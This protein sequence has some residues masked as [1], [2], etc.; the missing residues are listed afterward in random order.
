MEETFLVLGTLLKKL[1]VFGGGVGGCIFW[2]FHMKG[3]IS[4][5][6]LGGYLFFIIINSSTLF[7]LFMRRIHEEEREK[8]KLCLLP[9][10]R[11]SRRVD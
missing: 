4:G 9:M 7:S 3:C 1:A 6:G 8:G 11:D 10:V 5:S 2:K